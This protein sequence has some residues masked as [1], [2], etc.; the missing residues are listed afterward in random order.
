MCVCVRVNIC[1]CECKC[2]C[3]PSLTGLTH[4]WMNSSPL[5]HSSIIVIVGFLRE[6]EQPVST[7][8]L[9]ICL[10][11]SLSLSLSLAL[12]LFQPVR[13]R[14]DLRSLI[15]TSAAL[16]P[17]ETRPLGMHTNILV[18]Q[19]FGLCAEKLHGCSI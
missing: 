6:Q 18:L 17:L 1:V 3:E 10:S 8:A 7:A 13:L 5:S 15:L 12:G 14:V 2:V 11:V 9:L 19:A 4:G 16:G